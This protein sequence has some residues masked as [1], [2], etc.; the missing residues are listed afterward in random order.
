MRQTNLPGQNR[1]T[2]R[3]LAQSPGDISEFRIR[4]DRAKKT[5][6]ELGAGPTRDAYQQEVD[7]LEAAI[8]IYQEQ[9]EH[10]DALT[11]KT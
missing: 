2:R 8:A 4:I 10:I 11:R 9:R 5:V 6:G 1:M 3:Y 7:D